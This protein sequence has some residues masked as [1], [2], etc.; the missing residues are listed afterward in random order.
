MSSISFIIACKQSYRKGN[1]FTGVCLSTGG[2]SLCPGNLY[3]GDSM[4]M[5]ISVRE[6]PQYS[7]G[8]AVRILLECFLIS[9][10]VNMLGMALR[11]AGAFVIVF[12]VPLVVFIY[13]SRKRSTDPKRQRQVYLSLQS[14]QR[15]LGQGT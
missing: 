9:L 15:V 2:G 6:N 5:G 8:R 11:V 4:F 1:V 14:Y 3:L 7:E 10:G 12:L 13:V